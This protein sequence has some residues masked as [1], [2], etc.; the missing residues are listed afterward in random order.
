MTISKYPLP[1]PRLSSS[2]LDTGIWTNAGKKYEDE[3]KLNQDYLHPYLAR[4]LYR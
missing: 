4:D 1:L 2:L 3:M